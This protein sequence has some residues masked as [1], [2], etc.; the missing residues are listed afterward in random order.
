MPSE[1][2]VLQSESEPNSPL[3][4]FEENG[5]VLSV[6]A[7]T[8]EDEAIAV[9][10]RKGKWISQS[11]VKQSAMVALV[12]NSA[13]N[14][15]LPARGLTQGF[16]TVGFSTSIQA[17]TPSKIDSLYSVHGVDQ[18]HQFL[19][20]HESLIDFLVTAHDKIQNKF[21]LES[22]SLE[23]VHDRDDASARHLVVKITTERDFG[24]AIARRDQF[25]E[26]W[27]SKHGEFGDYLSIRL[28]F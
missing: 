25:D 10:R 7:E 14:Q 9:D 23:M 1:L 28:V 4:G 5:T 21:P 12:W 8:Q 2:C 17:N 26:W 16:H 27:L 22:L 19:E 3:G 24:D 18:V 20:E 15:V 13:T 11:L 6:S